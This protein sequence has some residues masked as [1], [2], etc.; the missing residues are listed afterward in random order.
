LREKYGS[1]ALRPMDA[2][3]GLEEA[4]QREL[5]L[6]PVAEALG[7]ADAPE[8]C[9]HAAA[10]EHLGASGLVA[11]PHRAGEGVEQP[12]ELRAGRGGIGLRACGMR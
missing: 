11:A 5:R 6:E 4:L 10:V 2:T 8:R 1:V 12:V 7:A 3:V 9:R